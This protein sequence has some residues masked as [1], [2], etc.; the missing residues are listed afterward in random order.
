MAKLE[1][2]LVCESVSVDQRTNRISLFNVVEN[3]N[4]DT[5]PGLM[6]EVVAA[7]LWRREDGDQTRDFQATLRLTG[8]FDKPIESRSNFKL[9]DQRHRTFFLLQG[10]PVPRA[11]D[12]R[13][14]LLLNDAHVA[15][16][17]VTVATGPA[18][19]AH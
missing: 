19:P 16:H 4:A 18:G 11:G 13:F 2:F 3:V 17:I 7:A 9:V 8:I 15:E 1:F 10:V 14:E 12:L 5:F 6:T